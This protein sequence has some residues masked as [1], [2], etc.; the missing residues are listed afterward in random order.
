M[1]EFIAGL[2]DDDREMREVGP[3]GPTRRYFTGRHETPPDGFM[4]DGTPYWR[5]SGAGPASVSTWAHD[6]ARE[7]ERERERIALLRAQVARLAEG[8]V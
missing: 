8:E 5:G 3:P 2:P 6:K 4:S 1:L 7:R